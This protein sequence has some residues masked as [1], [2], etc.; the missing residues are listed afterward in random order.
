MKTAKDEALFKDLVRNARAGIEDADYTLVVVDAAKKIT[1]DLKEAL[2]SLFIQANQ[3]GGRIDDLSLDDKGKVVHVR[4]PKS[5]SQGHEKF[6]IVLNKVDLVSPKEKLL[7]I[8]TELGLLGD[9]CVEYGVEVLKN[10][11]DFDLKRKTAESDEERN[12]WLAES[13][14]VFFISAKDNDGVEELASYLHD[15]S[16]PTADFALP[17]GQVTSMSIAERVEE[18]IREKIYRCLHKEVPHSVRQ[19]NRLLQ[20]GRTGDGK[21]VLRVDQ[22]LLVRTKSHL[23]LVMGRSGMTL[24][25]I[26]ETAKRD[27]IKNLRSEGIDDVLLNLR[28][29]LSKSQDHIRGL[30]SE[31]YGAMQY[32]P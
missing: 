6:A 13:P 16:T 10:G 12:K 24:K 15:L 1:D 25:R 3:T 4:V 27:L 9:N 2:A 18:I 8:A 29:K 31:E 21:L 20:Q 28:V 11:P 7:E 22:V 32:V 5:E 23:R 19:M 26:E 17:P 14:P 30:E